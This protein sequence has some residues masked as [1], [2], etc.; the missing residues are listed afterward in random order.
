MRTNPEQFSC[1]RYEKKVFSP[2]KVSGLTKGSHNIVRGVNILIFRICL[3]GMVHLRTSQE[4]PPLPTTKSMVNGFGG[5]THL[6]TNEPPC[7]RNI[8]MTKRT[9]QIN[10]PRYWEKTVFQFIGLT[11]WIENLTSKFVGHLSGFTWNYSHTI[12]TANTT[13]TDQILLPVPFPRETCS[14][15]E[16]CT[17]QENVWFLLVNVFTRVSFVHM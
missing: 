16:I 10:L 8:S 9:S 6:E 12:S 5:F 2:K 3:A 14:L 15:S 13:T 1:V 11:L 7:A 17:V 4:G